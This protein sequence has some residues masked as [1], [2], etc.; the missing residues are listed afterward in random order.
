MLAFQLRH[1]GIGEGDAV[2]VFLPMLPET[3]AAVMA[4]AKLGAVFLPIFSG[5]GVD[6]IA[7][8]LGDAD[9]KAIITAAQAQRR[10]KTVA[11]ATTAGG[12]AA[13]CRRARD[14]RRRTGIG[15]AGPGWSVPRRGCST[16]STRCSSPTRRA[17]RAARR[18]RC[19]CTAASS[20]KIAEEVAFQFD[21]RPGDRLFW[22]ADMGWIMG[23]WEIVGALANGAT[24][25]LYDGAPDFPGPDRLWAYLERHRV[26]IL[27]ISPTLIRSLMHHGEAPVRPTISPR[28]ASSAPRASRGTRIRGAG[29]SRDRGTG[30]LSGHQHLGRNGGG[31]VLPV[32]PSRSSRIDPMT[33]RRARVGDGRRRVRRQRPAPARGGR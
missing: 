4:V 10:G 33:P 7:V 11:M 8:R 19:T 29:T 9:A 13:A 30:S 28:C 21:V 18:A 3:V 31:R 24:V 16:A 5:Y 17:R 12:A 26:T 25:C 2:G 14:R 27:G 1:H 32:A 20:V 6:A 23:P 15:L 22:F